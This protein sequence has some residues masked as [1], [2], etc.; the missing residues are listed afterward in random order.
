MTWN[1]KQKNAARARRARTGES[2]QR[3]IMA[4]RAGEPEPA[5]RPAPADDEFAAVW[6]EDRKEPG[7]E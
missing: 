7:T 4:I 3:A 6:R 2:Y 5:P 1:K